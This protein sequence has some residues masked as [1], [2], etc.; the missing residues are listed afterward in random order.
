M[1]EDAARLIVRAL[2]ERVNEPEAIVLPPAL[3]VRASTARN[4]T[5]SAA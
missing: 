2:K 1:G 3:V 5:I 4:G